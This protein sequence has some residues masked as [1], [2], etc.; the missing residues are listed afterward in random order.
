I[1]I[2]EA[3]EGVEGSDGPRP[4]PVST[5]YARLCQRLVTALTA[6][7]PEGRLYEVDMRLRPSGNA[8]PAA[9]SFDSFRRYHAESAWTWEH[10]ALTRARPVAG[11]PA[12]AARVMEEIRR[13]LARPRAQERLVLDV[14]E[15]PEKMAAARADGAG[16]R[17]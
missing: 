2:Y 5:W 10:M 17:G 8:G 12:L 14:A 1:L 7:T 4:L 3:P 6:L 9:S 16:R 13:V 15:M 11:D